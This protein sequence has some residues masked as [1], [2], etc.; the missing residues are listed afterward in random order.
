MFRLV[1]RGRFRSAD[2]AADFALESADEAEAE[3]LKAAT[4]A[5]YR[6]RRAG[7]ERSA[8]SARNMIV[9]ISI[10][11]IFLHYLLAADDDGQVT[12]VVV[13]VSRKNHPLAA[14]GEV[15]QKRATRVNSD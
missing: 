15:S 7:R 12:V 9:R 4:A 2:S 3:E 6:A 10:Q 5:D 11:A 13:F 8:G 1:F 14:A